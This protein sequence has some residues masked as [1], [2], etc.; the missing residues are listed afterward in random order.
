MP[1][2]DDA[3][4]SRA[5][6][7]IMLASTPDSRDAA[8]AGD[9][10]GIARQKRESRAAG[11][12]S[13]VGRGPRT[14]PN[15]ASRMGGRFVFAVRL[16]HSAVR[17][18]APRPT[19][20]SLHRRLASASARS[21][22]PSS[23]RTRNGPLVHSRTKSASNQPCAIISPAIASASAPSVPGPHRQPMIRLHRQSDAA[24]IDHDELG[25]ACAR[26]GDPHRRPRATRCSDCGP[27]AGC[28]RPAR[29]PVCPSA[30]RW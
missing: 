6:L 26:I 30:S 22:V 18:R 29:S 24:R 12:R 19:R 23:S 13:V 14:D 17:S 3:I 8:S 27:T 15:S 10:A 1:P 16:D 20:Q 5:A 2:A 25:A 21:R 7:R 9:S 4:A 11:D 28:S